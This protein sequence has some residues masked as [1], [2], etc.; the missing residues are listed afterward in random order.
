VAVFDV[1]SDGGEK[2]LGDARG[3]FQRSE[4]SGVAE[5]DWLRHW[6][7]R[8]VGL[9]FR[10]TYLVHCGGALPLMRKRRFRDEA[11]KRHR[12]VPN[13]GRHRAPS[14]C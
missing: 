1:W 12:D 10:H 11:I 9:T 8:K 3:L 2:A 5:R 6:K 14:P 7:H 4:V 13:D